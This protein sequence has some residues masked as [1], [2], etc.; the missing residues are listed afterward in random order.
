MRCYLGQTLV[1]AGG[2]G[3]RSPLPGISKAAEEGEELIVG[4]VPAG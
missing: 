3:E 1:A 4:L 2:L